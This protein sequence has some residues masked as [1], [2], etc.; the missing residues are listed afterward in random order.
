[1]RKWGIE[2]IKIRYTKSIRNQLCVMELITISVENMI[3]PPEDVEKKELLRLV[4]ERVQKIRDE[5]SNYGRLTLSAPQKRAYQATIE[6]VRRV[7]DTELAEIASLDFLNCLLML[8]ED[9]R[10]VSKKMVNRTLAY[11]WA[12]LNDLMSQW[13]LLDDPDLENNSDI[14][15]G[16]L[17]AKKMK[18]AMEA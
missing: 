7:L 9:V 3:T 2:M 4:A 5:L 8:V 11:H 16:I 17:I 12:K 18:E 6:R 14:E 10:D 15:R 13:Y 1:V